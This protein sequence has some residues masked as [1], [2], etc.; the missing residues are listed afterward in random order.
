[1]ALVALALTLVPNAYA[2]AEL[3]LSDGL[4]DSVDILDNGGTGTCVGV[5]AADCI[6]KN[7][8]VNVVTF[9]GTIG[10]WSLNVST[11]S[12]HGAL[13]GTDLDLNSVNS[14]TA[15]GALTIQFSDD[16]FTSGARQFSVGGTVSGSSASLSFSAFAGASKF[17]PTNQF[18]TTQTV[19]FAGGGLTPFSVSTGGMAA[20]TALTEVAVLSFKGA[21]GTSFDAGLAPVP[22]PAS[23]ALLGGALLLTVG[24]IR[25][26]A[27]R[28]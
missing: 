16:G 10:T 8:A 17:A 3:K 7:A 12:S 24:A 20:G 1:M 13:G 14:T 5:A 23:V 22:E 11:G 19:N 27:R 18:G 6:D 28:S 25:R 21:G 9:I 2:T 15:A 26:K 4:G